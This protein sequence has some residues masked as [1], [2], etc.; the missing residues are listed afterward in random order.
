LQH[1]REV[2]PAANGC[3]LLSR[4]SYQGVFGLWT[5][6]RALNLLEGGISVVGESMMTWI[7]VF[8]D[9]ITVV[10]AGHRWHQV[11]HG[12]AGI[13]EESIILREKHPRGGSADRIGQY[14]I[15]L[16][17][18]KV[19]M[20]L[21]NAEATVRTVAAGYG[22]AFVSELAAAY[23]L[24]RGNVVDIPFEGLNLQRTI[25]MVRKRISAPTAATCLG[26]SSTISECQI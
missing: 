7:K 16:D 26:F 2:H 21:G 6:T 24:E 14:D 23:P 9:K 12:P 3:T 19:F 25:Y 15:S 20:E 1:R 13:A 8:K 5:R 18:L 10:P 11:V 4:Y 17:D 22:V